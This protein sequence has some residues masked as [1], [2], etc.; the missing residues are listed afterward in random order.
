M[1]IVLVWK[2]GRGVAAEFTNLQEC[3]SLITVLGVQNI[4][5][6]TL[7][8]GRGPLISDQTTGFNYE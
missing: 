1:G 5:Y 4:E 3:R 8:P 7:D 2:T 6:L